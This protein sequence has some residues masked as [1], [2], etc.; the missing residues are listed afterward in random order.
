MYGHAY[1]K[2]IDQSGKVGN[3][4]RGQLNRENEYFP[5]PVRA[6]ECG[7]WRDDFGSPVPRQPA[8]ISI[9]RLN[10]LVL[11]YGIIPRE[12]RGGGHLF[13]CYGN[14][15]SEYN[16]SLRLCRNIFGS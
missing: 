14:L 10:L 16:T 2:S 8:H 15:H 5:I 13:I 3:P 7:L 9:L 12:F 4:G 11:T 6:W 1:S